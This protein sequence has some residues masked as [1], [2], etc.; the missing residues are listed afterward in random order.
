M[1]LLSVK[2]LTKI[3]REA[4]LFTDVTFGLNLGEKAALIGRNGTGKSTLLNCIAGTLA[5]DNGTAI[6]NKESGVSFLPQNPIYNPDDTINKHIFNETNFEGKISNTSPKLAIIKYYETLC[7]K[8][9]ENQDIDQNEAFHKEYEFINN[10]MNEKNLWNYEAEVKSILEILGI[11]NGNDSKSLERKMGSLSGGMIKKVALAKVL[12]ED[13]KLLLLDEPTNHLDIKTITWLQDYLA[14]TEKSVLMVTHDRYFLDMVCTDIYELEHGKF[15]HYKGNFS[16]YLEKKQTELEIAQNTERRIESVLRTERDW[17]MRGPCARGTKAR[18]RVDNIHRLINREKLKEDKVF[19]FEVVG[20]RLGGKILEING[21]S[22]D[23]QKA[24]TKEKVSVIKDFS[25]IFKKGERIGV[26]GNNGSGK[27]TFLNIITGNLEPDSGSVEKGLNTVFAYYQQNPEFKDVSLTCLEY[28]KEAAEYVTTNDGK[29]LSAT[30]MLEQFGFEGKIQYSPV[31]TLSGGE[32]KRLFLVRLLISNPNFLVLDEPTNDFDIFTMSILES[33]LQDFAGCLLIVSHDRYFMDKIADTLFI[34]EDDGSISGYVGKC[35]EYIE[36][37]KEEEKLKKAEE[38]ANAA[39]SAAAANKTGTAAVEEKTVEQSQKPEQVRKR[40]FKEQ[41]E[42][43]E[44]ENQ[45][46]E[47]EERKEELESILSGGESNHE[48][49]AEAGKEYA[50]L[51]ENL[52]KMYSR[53][54]EL[55][56]L[57]PY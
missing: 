34:L 53:W 52:E 22:K 48:K 20:R 24:N 36:F 9:A 27:S 2:N 41:K 28:I 29:T 55:G 38:K 44:L 51:Q 15:N 1:T 32:R 25:Y 26:F 14:T 50:T 46:F 33:F 40:T 4:P 16:T 30:Q 35:S 21:I 18:A 19:A 42:F 8:L 3:G 39:K 37:K 6:F 47:M 17:L 12:V 57:R 5:P 45:I 13:S 49:I 11:Y 56:V 31:S 54:E 7:E 43:E 23:F 10:L